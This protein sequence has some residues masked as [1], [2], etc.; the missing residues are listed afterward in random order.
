MKKTSKD[1]GFTLIE[2][3]VAITLFAIGILGA[4]SMQIMALQTNAKAN[5]KTE[6]LAVASEQME[7]LINQDYADIDSSQTNMVIGDDANENVSD[8]YTL[9]WNV[10]DDSPV[11]D[12]KTITVTV[13]WNYKGQHTETISR[14][15]SN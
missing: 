12:T 15:V 7:K 6:A 14:I 4:T 9:S 3:L 2:I 11:N 13:T 8:V 5:R 1:E 10:A